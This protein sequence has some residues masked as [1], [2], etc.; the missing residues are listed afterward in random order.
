MSVS[1][2]LPVGLAL[3]I[4][5]P[6]VLGAW[7][8]G[9]VIARGRAAHAWGASA[10]GARCTLPRAFWSAAAQVDWSARVAELSI[11]NATTGGVAIDRQGV[12]QLVRLSLDTCRML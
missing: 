2:L 3:P 10:C 6:W 7:D 11:R 9:A 4:G 8:I 1:W 12:A 5:R